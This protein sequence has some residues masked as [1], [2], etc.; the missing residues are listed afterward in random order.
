MTL[1]PDPRTP[2]LA[3]DAL[4]TRFKVGGAF[5]RPSAVVHAAEEV[6]FEVGRGEIVGLVGES[7]S[8][9]STVSRTILRLERATAGSVRFDGDEV[10]NLK[11]RALAGFRRRVAAVFQDPA[12]SLDPRMRVG[13]IV[14]E[15]LLAHRL[16]GQAERR[17]RAAALL[18]QVGLG[19]GDARRYPHEFSGGQRQRVAIARA[20]A[21]GP[22]LIVADEPVSALDVSV[23]AQV[24][25][26]LLSLRDELGLALL[27][28]SHDLP[29]VEFLCDRVVVM[30]LG[31][32]MERAPAA[33]FQRAPLHPYSQMLVLSAPR[34]GERL[35]RS[36]SADGGETPSPLAPPSGCVF[37]TRC[38]RATP[39]CALAVPPLE[40]V[41]PGRWV[42]CIH[43]GAP[44]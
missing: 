16:A 13:E 5:G 34:F 6:S 2:L 31:R 38:S 32:V 37:R 17:D 43:L 23:Q 15:P 40:Q 14:T 4:T 20:L 29:T 26:L 39:E 25:N 10:L 33:Q 19:A 35:G 12:T 1:A 21:A 27:F 30:Y 8:G 44:A 42:A 22:D 18:T 11:G 24:I 3:L 28:I 36:V 7:G 9:K 41:A